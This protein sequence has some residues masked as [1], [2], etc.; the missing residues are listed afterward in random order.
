[1]NHI[2]RY[3]GLLCLALSC[4]GTLQLFG[5]NCDT[6]ITFEQD[7][8]STAH[9]QEVY[10]FYRRIAQCYDVADL[11]QIGETDAGY[12]LNALVIDGKQGFAPREVSDHR[13][14]L[15]IN[16]GIHPGEPCGIDASMIWVRNLLEHQDLSEILDR[17]IIVVIPAL[18]I[19]GMLNRGSYSRVNQIGPLEYGFRGNAKNLDLNRDFM[20]QDSRNVRALAAFMAR[21]DPDLF[22]DTHTTNGSDHQ[23]VMTLISNARDRLESEMEELV[24]DT[25][26]PE[27][28]NAMV[29]NG[30]ETGPYIESLHEDPA[31]GIVAFD[32]KPRYSMG[33]AA[34]LHIP[35]ITSEAHMLKSY[36]GRVRATYA[37]LDHSLDLLIRHRT[38]W[39]AARE[40]SRSAYAL[41]DSMTLSWTLDTDIVHKVRYAGYETTNRPSEI[42]GEDRLVYDRSRPYV[43]SVDYFDSYHPD[44]RTA[45]PQAY[46]IPC[47]YEEVISRLRE[48][49]VHMR[50]L[51]A[52]SSVQ[53]VNYRIQSY[54]TTAYPYE[55]HY[56][57][58]AVD[59]RVE[60]APYRARRGDVWITANQPLRRLIVSLLEPHAED[61]YFA[62]NYFDGILMQK[63]YYSPYLFEEIAPELLKEDESLSKAFYEKKKSDPDF[64]SNAKA[65][66]DYIYR[67]S[68]YYEATHNL[69]PVGRIF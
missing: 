29:Q 28:T 20:K 36:V 26:L 32:D 27:L 34:L 7:S 58:Y 47:A 66:L 39:R 41:M 57:H 55:S 62:W 67:H 24:Y 42:T 65:Q 3:I 16:N 48:Q 9:Y 12:S 2:C 56:L 18:N 5:Q 54:Q 1:M 13:V 10:G 37:L 64:A 45:I 15:L 33:Y 30:F 49:G 50:R 14:M 51:T 59:V 11:L 53:S 68:P 31:R 8:Q 40:N 60:K 43:R 61:S 17:A 19:G 46:V 23:Y 21:W 44:V 38:A 63:E 69:Y 35:S 4:F 22:I 52:D 25:Y 6:Y